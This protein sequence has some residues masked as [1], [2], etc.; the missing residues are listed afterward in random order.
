MDRTLLGSE[1]AKG[2]FANERAICE[3]FNNWQDDI[4]AREWLGIMRY[5]IAKLKSVEAIQIPTRISKSDLD[6]YNIS[7]EE[8]C[9]FVKYQK[10]DAQISIAIKIGDIIKMEYISLK[11]ANIK[12]DFNQIDKRS[13]DN[14][15]EM[16]KFDDKVAFW[17][18][19]FTGENIPKQYL[20]IIGKMELRDNRRL[21]LDEIPKD[22]QGKILTFFKENR[23]L[24][25]SDIIK[26]RG[27]LSAGW[28]LVTRKSIDSM[29]TDWILKDINTVMNFYGKG[30]VNITNKG[31]LKIGKVT[32]QRKG[33]TGGST[34]MQFKFKPCQLFELENTNGN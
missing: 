33:G 17:L 26:G 22:V 31:S 9:E 19:L 8:Y 12:A 6:K 34:K 14:Y 5:N 32:L 27:G 23:I 30:E 16:W 10:A 3:K 29:T 18:K 28:M 11:K 1:T 13:V 21:F 24:I 4:E 15:Q 7:E 20:S 2:G 25:V